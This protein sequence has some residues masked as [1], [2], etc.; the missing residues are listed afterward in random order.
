MNSVADIRL[1]TLRKF[2][3]PQGY[4]YERDRRDDGL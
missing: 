2:L 1:T 3:D 4:L